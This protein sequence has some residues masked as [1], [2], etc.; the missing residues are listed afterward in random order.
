MRNTHTAVTP[1]LD[2]DHPSIARLIA[3]HGWATL[4]VGQ[5]IGAVYTFV[6]DQIR[7]GYNLGD[8]IPASRV[9]A[10]R[11]GQCNTKTTL[12]MALL[13]A[14]GVPCRFHGATIHK[15]LQR[16]V[17]TGLF[18]WLAPTDIIHSWAEV[19]VDGR[20]VALEGVI[21]DQPY[22]DG[23]RGFL[24][25]ERG[26]FLGYG[27]GTDNLLAPAIEWKGVDTS[28]Q[29][30]GVNRDHGTFDDPD[31]FYAKH[32]GN[33]SGAKAWLYRRWIRHRMNRRVASIRGAQRCAN[34][35]VS[36]T[37]GSAARQGARAP[38]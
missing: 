38:R 23:L 17:V 4:P 28:I 10:D 32:G 7:F 2:F 13:R 8:R 6:R 14:V 35:P 12:V 31:A 1:L 33:L 11:Y 30:T 36:A 5:R 25:D 29:M 37:R 22:L 34:P 26:A 21:L 24:P 20:W 18:Y 16:G 3:E 19:Q 9:L 15:R 27:V